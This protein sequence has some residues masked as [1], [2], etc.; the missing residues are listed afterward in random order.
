MCVCVCVCVLSQVMASSYNDY[1]NCIYYMICSSLCILNMLHVHLLLPLNLHLDGC[2]CIP[3]EPL[4]IA[5]MLQVYLYT[6]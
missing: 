4:G 2:L 3:Q 6:T 5:Y 1:A